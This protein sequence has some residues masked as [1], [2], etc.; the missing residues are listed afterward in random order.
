[1]SRNELLGKTF[2][3]EGGLVLLALGGDYFREI[4][5]LSKP[6]LERLT[7]P[8]YLLMSVLPSVLVL[9]MMF[10]PLLY[11]RISYLVHTRKILEDVLRLMFKNCGPLTLFFVAVMAG[12]GEEFFFRGLIQNVLVGYLGVL[13]GLLLGG[14]IFGLAHM[15]TPL[16]GILATLAGVIL[17]GVYLYYDNLLT[18]ILVHALY[19][20]F[21]FLYFR[22]IHSDMAAA[23]SSIV[24]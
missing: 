3:L 12:V 11:L 18:P 8:G 6:G 24:G 19:D 4:S 21:A 2:L 23:D 15:V 22:Y 20:Y 14:L 5:F 16:Y 17:G 13:P 1:M 10:F 7:Q 9:A